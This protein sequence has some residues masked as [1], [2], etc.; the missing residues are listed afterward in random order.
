MELLFFLLSW[1]D[2]EAIEAFGDGQQRTKLHVHT[3]VLAQESYL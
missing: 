3:C 2:A 1:R